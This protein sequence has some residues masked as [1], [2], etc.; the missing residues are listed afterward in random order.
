MLAVFPRLLYNLVQ[1]L[2]APLWWAG[3]MGG[4]PRSRWVHIRVR[5]RLVEIE[6]PLPSLLRFVPG[7]A[8]AR[9]TSLTLLRR[10]VAYLLEDR[11]IVGVVVDLPPLSAGWAHCAGLRDQLTAL[12]DGGKTV[13]AY[14]SSG[15]GNRELYVASAADRILA[16]PAVQLA[17]LGLS[18]SV[19]YFKGL[20]D[21]AGLEVEVL[22]RAEYKT[23]AEP[24]VRQDMSP[25]QR[26]QLEALLG[27][28]DRRLR[29][30]LAARPGLDAAKVDALFQQALL[31]PEAAL[32]E[33]LIDGVC[34][35]DELPT[36]LTPDG[37]VT[38][39]VRAPRYF[40]WRSA[41]WLAPLLKTPF[42]A[43]VPVHGA[44]LGGAPGTRGGLQV[45][46]LVTTLRAAAR[47]PHVQ[48]VVLHVD[49][50][51]GSA[52]ASDRLHR[53]VKRLAEAKP[54]VAC[55]G[56]VAASGGYYVAAS[57]ASV[58]AQPL[59]VTGS[60]GVVAARPVVEPL[61][62][63]FGVSVDTVRL[64]PHADM[65]SKP[66]RLED[67]E[68]E[69]LDREIGTFY[70]TFVGVVAEGRARPRDEIEALARGRVWAGADAAER[71]RVDRL[72][73]L[74]VAV[75]EVTRL[76]EE[77]GRRVPEP[78]PPRYFR[79][80]RLLELPPADPPTKRAA[81]AALGLVDPRLRD[82]FGLVLNGERVLCYA[83]GLPTIR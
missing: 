3:W 59:T 78:L 75:Q 31:G 13:V 54:V 35:E 36:A 23:A 47:D 27:T 68:R 10:L 7:L 49:S 21:R 25:A 66:G 2:T 60:I 69:I 51:G 12:R 72:G 39:L 77:R 18:A 22:R 76:L 16:H 52:V 41:R 70:E 63:R 6:R 37:T 34:Y 82:T 29:E 14:L 38:R 73:G 44:I 50:P 5:P 61:L 71:G 20:L 15:G 33:G 64:A 17:P 74:D 62:S 80:R 79:A 24:A 1:L 67:A 4:R 28:F 81:R 43:V 83:A 11:R 58:V 48:G 46:G 45:S 55:F 32:S 9:P 42:V 19:P 57:A 26:E 8:E 56:D 65:L 40:A 53:E 30:G